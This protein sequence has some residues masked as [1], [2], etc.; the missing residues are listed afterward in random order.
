M[1]SNPNHPWTRPAL[2]LLVTMLA[3]T[4]AAHAE[5]EPAFGVTLDITYVSKYLWHGYDLFDDHAALQPS[6]DV[7][8]FGTGFSFNVWGSIPAGTGIL[9]HDDGINQWQEYDYTLAYATTIFADKPYALDLGANYIYYDF[10]KLDKHADTQEV[11]ASI[12]LP[13]LFPICDSGLVPSYYAGAFFP[14]ESSLEDDV[15]GWWHVFAL[16]YDLTTD[17]IIPGTET[18]IFNFIWDITFNDGVFGASTDW[19]HTT[20]G[21]AAPVECGPVTVT[22]FV[23]IQISMDDSVNHEDEV[24]GGVSVSLTF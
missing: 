4:A 1:N 19:S 15:A 22:P 23:N 9:E 3:L 18:Q 6:V 16:S 7:D 20:F 24:Y 11:G 5:D 14:T 13:N 21:L 10:P 8:L 12:A 17:P 2:T